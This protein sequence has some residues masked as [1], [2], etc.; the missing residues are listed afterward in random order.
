MGRKTCSSAS[1]R[2]ARSSLHGPRKSLRCPCS[3]QPTREPSRADRGERCQSSATRSIEARDPKPLN[4]TIS[5]WFQKQLASSELDALLQGLQSAGWGNPREQGDLQASSWRRLA[6]RSGPEQSQVAT[7]VDVDPSVALDCAPDDA[8]G[9]QRPRAATA[10]LAHRSM[11][12]RAGAVNQGD[13]PHPG[14]AVQLTRGETGSD[15][16]FRAAAAER[17]AIPTIEADMA[18]P[19]NAR[20][21]GL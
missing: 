6:S 18:S 1:S 11:T 19:Q 5:S 20:R 15:A 16:M 21:R 10:R 14:D 2:S 3:R 17:T 12:Y 7:R 13:A 4:C 8:S 9:G